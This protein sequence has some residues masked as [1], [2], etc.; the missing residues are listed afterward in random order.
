MAIY[1]LYIRFTDN[2]ERRLETRP[3]HREYL[4][5]LYDSGK[6]LESGPFT[7]D[8]GAL[9]V[10]ESENL[11]AAEAQ[12]AQDPYSIAG[13]IVESVTFHEWNRVFPPRA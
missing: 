9:I 3:V 7:D 8:S 6:L 5:S 11:A 12:F 1:A 10:Y 4:K 13:G 2:E